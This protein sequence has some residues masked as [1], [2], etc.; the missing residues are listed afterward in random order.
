M[1]T[2]I[3]LGYAGVLLPYDVG[4]ET[5]TGAISVA[6]PKL[7]FSGPLA[8]LLTSFDSVSIVLATWWTLRYGRKAT[9]DALPESLSCRVVDDVFS[10]C[11]CKFPGTHQI[12]DRTKLTVESIR[13]RR[14]THWLVLD[15]TACRW[16]VQVLHRALLLHPA[17]GLCSPQALEHLRS[18]LTRLT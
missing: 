7:A 18:V 11:L 9:V 1:N 17:M 3:Y 13:R 12:P 16:P 14:N 10:E 5:S 6:L 8:E 15:H 4:T 2:D